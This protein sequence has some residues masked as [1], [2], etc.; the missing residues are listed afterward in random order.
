VL[1]GIDLLL[2]SF[3]FGRS[4][5]QEVKDRKKQA[6][7][8]KLRERHGLLVEDENSAVSSA[9]SEVAEIYGDVTPTSSSSA[10]FS[11]GS[12]LV[13]KGTNNQK[14]ILDDDRQQ[15]GLVDEVG[16]LFFGDKTIS[17]WISVV[18]V[19][20]ALN[21]FGV[22]VFA[23]PQIY[24]Q[25]GWMMPTV[26]IIASCALSGFC[27]TFLCDAIAR[28]DENGRFDKRVEFEGAARFFC[29]GKVAQVC[30]LLA[31]FFLSIRSVSIINQASQAV[32]SFI[33]YLIGKTYALQLFP[34]TYV[35]WGDA[36][37]E[38]CAASTSSLCIP[39]GQS[40]GGARDLS[41]VDGNWPPFVITAG[42]FVLVLTVSPLG[43]LSM[44]NA[45]W[46]QILPVSLLML[47]VS[48]T[49]V[50]AVL[51]PTAHGSGSEGHRHTGAHSGA[52]E[53]SQ[54]F[55]LPAFGAAPAAALEIITGGFACVLLLPSW[56][57]EKRSEVRVNRVVWASFAFTAALYILVGVFGAY[58]YPGLHE[59][60]V[61]RDLYDGSI[62]HGA[63]VGHVA[64]SASGVHLHSL[65]HAAAAAAESSEGGSTDGLLVGSRGMG[66]M[67]DRSSLT[68]EARRMESNTPEAQVLLSVMM[69]P[70][71]K[72]AGAA[73][74]GLP[75]SGSVEKAMRLVSM[76]FGG[77][78][79]AFAV[80]LFGIVMR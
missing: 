15:V 21:A 78:G 43:W 4:Y 56:L 34:F 68:M 75:L 73:H 40:G 24:Q 48:L 30:V 58:S 2:L 80:P 74:V 22:G 1:L 63:H 57:H 69:Q 50:R 49:V 28:I 41:P 55:W 13:K 10:N 59:L 36:E 72:G 31:C 6:Q 71:K 16:I 26:L 66:V 5:L 79:M 62:P 67:V 23:M 70:P 65:R 7:K 37:W 44:G 19:I 12:P 47:L 46:L 9:A 77:F 54:D 14:R 53:M 61:A 64:G 38:A 18:L 17:L 32:D 33:V 8:K 35:E 39:F 27:A 11:E 42:Y 76:L 52:Y 60:Q 29:G 25:A 20:S 3:D 51:T 45:A